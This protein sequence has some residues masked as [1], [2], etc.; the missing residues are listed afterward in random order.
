MFCGREVAGALVA[1][2]MAG[3]GLADELRQVALSDLC[4]T[5]GEI[6]PAPGGRLL[7]EAPSS[8]AVLRSLTDAVAEID[9]RYLGPS[10]GAKPLAS[11]ELRRQIGLKLRAKDTCNLVYAMWHIEPDTRIA[12]SIKRN[13]GMSTHEQC[14]AHG[15]VNLKPTMADNAHKVAPGEEHS[16]RAEL[17][18]SRLTVIADGKVAWSGD[19]SQRVFEFDGPVGLRSDNARFNF[20]FLAGKARG[21]ASIPHCEPSAGD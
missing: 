15:Y 18:D 4:V 19:L 9:F 7:V 5:N 8:R 21:G 17:H 10:A 12:V 16:L 11:G 3:P 14:D 6:K 2:V 1:F 13:P 20:V